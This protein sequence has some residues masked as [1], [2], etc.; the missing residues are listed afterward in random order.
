MHVELFSHPEIDAGPVPGL[1]VFDSP[2]ARRPTPTCWPGCRRGRAR[3]TSRRRA[4][5][6]PDFHQKQ[7]MEMPSSVAVAT[8]TPSGR[9]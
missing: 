8:P 4:I 6:L 1:T 2:E 9:R 3:P 5:V 7:N